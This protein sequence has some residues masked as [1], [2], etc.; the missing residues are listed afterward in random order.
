MSKICWRCN[1]LK[2]LTEF[3]RRG[4]G[5]QAWCKACRRSYDA[6]YHQRNKQKRLAQKRD[7]ELRWDAWYQALKS[8]QCVY[9]GGTFHPAAMQFDHPPGVRKSGNVGDIRR[10][11][12]RPRLLAEIAKCELVCANCHAMRTFNRRRGVAQPG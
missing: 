8:G 7:L 6:L 3:H 1:R 2:P 10:R 11:H 4:R 12:N 9:C 5:Y